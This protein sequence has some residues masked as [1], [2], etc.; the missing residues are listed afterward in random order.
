MIA[1]E[2]SSITVSVTKKI[3][4]M[5]WTSCVRRPVWTNP[6]RTN[7]SFVEQHE[8]PDP[9]NRAGNQHTQHL[10]AG[11]LHGQSSQSAAIFHRSR[12]SNCDSARKS[13]AQLDETFSLRQCNLVT[14]LAGRN[15]FVG[16][17]QKQLFQRVIP[18]QVDGRSFCYGAEERSLPSMITPIRSRF[19]RPRRAYEST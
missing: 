18:V 14:P 1:D 8:Q 2:N 10:Q 11:I 13:A 16:Q 7:E 3:L 5:T 17:L 6:D 12:Q 9:K 15:L 19:L 4:N